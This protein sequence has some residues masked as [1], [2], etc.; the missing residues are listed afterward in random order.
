LTLVAPTL[1]SVLACNPTS[2]KLRRFYHLHGDPDSGC[3]QR[4]QYG[5]SQTASVSLVAPTLVSGLACNP[6]SLSVITTTQT[7]SLSL[8]ATTLVSALA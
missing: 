8:V 7:M 1:V 5:P 4:R 3:P 2:V 6:A